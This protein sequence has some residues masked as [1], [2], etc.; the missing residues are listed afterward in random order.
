M[1]R[2][3]IVLLT[4]LIATC[5]SAA[6]LL[7]NLQKVSASDF[8]FQDRDRATDFHALGMVDRGR[9]TF[10]YDTFGDEDFWGGTLQIHQAIKGRKLGGVGPGVDPATALAVGLKVDED[11]LPQSVIRALKAGKINLKDPATTVTLLRLNAVVGLTGFFDHSGNL[12][13]VGIQC[14][15][16]H[17][18]VDDSLAPGIGHRLDGW[19]NRDLNVG[20]IIAAAPDLSVPAGMLHVTQDQLRQVLKSWGP[21]KFDAAAFLDG[22]SGPVLIPPAFGLAGVALQTY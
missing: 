11:A 21:G 10:R 17:S 20:A 14:A 18:T 3:R 19:A 8:K 15:L 12:K 22:K 5:A 6:L 7:H 2:V 13:S 16:C 1:T 9:N 4:V